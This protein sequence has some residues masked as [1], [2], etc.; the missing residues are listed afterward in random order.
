MGEQNG[1]TIVASKNWQWLA[2]VS[3][4]NTPTRE[5]YLML[6]LFVFEI[7]RYQARALF[8]RAGARGSLCCRAFTK[9]T[10]GSL[11][12][13]G[14]YGTRSRAVPLGRFFFCLALVFLP[15]TH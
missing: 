14:P 2:R 1:Y 6:A 12:Y 4:T 11:R 9:G 3:N 8:L 15:V 13:V 7:A 10:P 5:M